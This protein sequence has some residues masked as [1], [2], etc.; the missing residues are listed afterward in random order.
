MENRV[1]T[2]DDDKW[3]SLGGGLLKEDGDYLQL[4]ARRVARPGMVGFD[5]GCFTGWTASC[6]WP[7]FKE[8]D[9]HFY[10]IDW[11]KGNIGTP[12]GQFEPGKYPADKVLL[13]LL[14]NIEVSDCLDLVSVIIAE[15]WK[16]AEIIADNTVDYVYIG[17]DHRYSAVKKDIAVWLPKVRPGGVLCGHAFNQEIEVNSRAWIEMN[18][19]PE[20]DYY[21]SNNL[22]FGVTKAVQELLPGYERGGI[23]IWS[24]QKSR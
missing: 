8:N 4:L 22:H 11:F 23:E 16:P 19:E 14:K 24:Y 18:K 15:S 6:V 13:Q 12:V 5:T 9:G 21:H 1:W 17:G 3:E 20:Q 2:K 7:I 10:C